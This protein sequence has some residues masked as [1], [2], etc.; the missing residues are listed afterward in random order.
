MKRIL[1]ILTLVLLTFQSL[2]GDIG[3]PEDGN[4]PIW[5]TI[6]EQMRLDEIGY[7]MRQTDP[8][9]QP[10]RS[11]AE[12]EPMSGVLIRYPLG[13]PVSL[14]A[15]LSEEIEVVTIVSSQNVQAQA[16]NTY[17]SNG[18]N[19]DN[20]SF[21]IAGTNSHWTRDYGPWFI[22]DGEYNIGIADFNYNRPRPLDNAI[23]GHFA[24]N[25]NIDYYHMGL[26][27]TGG[28]FM[29]DGKGVAASTQIAY[30]ENTNFTPAQVNQIMEDYLG[31]TDYHVVQDP[32]GTYIDHIDTWAKFLAPD[33]IMI[34]SVPESHSQYNA[35]EQAVSYFASQ[36]S[37]Y[38]NPYQIFRVYTPNNQPYTNS[39]ILNDRVFVPLTGSTWDNAAL[40]SFEEA[41][42]GYSIYG[43]QWGG[44]QSTDAL[45]CRTKEIAD[46]EMLYISHMPVLGEVDYEPLYVLNAF[47]Y[48]HSGEE[49]EP[50]SPSVFYR[51]NSGDF[52]Q[53]EMSELEEFNYQATVSGFVPG[54]TIAYYIEASDFSGRTSRKPFIGEYDPYIFTVNSQGVVPEI[55]HLPI[56]VVYMH[57]FPITIEVYVDSVVELSSVQIHYKINS[58]N[59]IAVD[60]GENADEENLWELLF[61]PDVEKGDEIYYKIVVISNT[62]PPSIVSFPASGWIHMEITAQQLEPVSFYPEPGLYSEE[63]AVEMETEVKN[64]VIYYTVDGSDPDIQSLVYSDPVIIGENTVFKALAWKEG[65]LESE[66]TTAEYFIELSTEKEIPLKTAK[67]I[68]AYPN[69]FNP[70][71]NF[72]FYLPESQRVSLSIYNFKGQLI[73]VAADR[74]FNKGYHSLI[75][76]SSSYNL[77]SGIYFYRMR[78]GE[79]DNTKK[80]ILLK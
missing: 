77:P 63:I 49:L 43:I 39:L 65:Y 21:M 46:S 18:V 78:A 8:P 69:P 62:D 40:Q 7:G 44:W 47:V 31:I 75:W 33:K 11:I 55:E 50:S 70:V 38:G 34:R 2:A 4:L 71:V 1:F 79:L 59:I 53:I 56:E 48:P 60:L 35:I 15:L 54:D 23:P 32:T 64:S 3:L 26:V 42:P 73:D 37:S 20:C 52:F 24:S 72:S 58:G 12:F 9:Y 22:F 76:D 41:M 74:T 45:H 17:Q 30:T 10:A 67:L 80:M 5:L 51:V 66:I 57:E 36:V 14:V 27:H 29:S 61:S 25:Y 68:S 13:I 16:V 6:E 19:M 28:N